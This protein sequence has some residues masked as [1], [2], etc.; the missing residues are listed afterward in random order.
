MFAQ[1]RLRAS[2]NRD[3]RLAAMDF[4]DVSRNSDTASSA[5][6]K[7]RRSRPTNQNRMWSMPIA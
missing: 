4:F 7:G 1:R 6:Q 5:E 2:A 3:R